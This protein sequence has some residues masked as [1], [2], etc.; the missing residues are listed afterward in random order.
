[1]ATRIVARPSTWT[2]GRRKSDGRAFWFIPGT[3]PGAVYCADSTDCT[4]PSARHS[5]DGTCKHTRAVS[6]HERSQQPTPA[7][8]PRVSY[9]SLFP[10]CRGCHD[11]ADGRDGYCY[12][13]ASDRERQA[14]RAV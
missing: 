10:P 6:E 12:A 5:K 4:C 11:V 3:T 8:K 2:R 14:R 1:M 7:S 13:C 9:E